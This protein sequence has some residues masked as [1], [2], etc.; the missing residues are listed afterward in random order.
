MSKH[1]PSR[2]NINEIQDSLEN[3]RENWEQVNSSLLAKRELLTQEIIENL[4]AGYSYVD[5]LIEN[6]IDIFDD[7]SKM[8][9][10][11]HIVLCWEDRSQWI[12]SNNHIIETRKS[13]ELWIDEILAWHEKKKRK[14]KSIYKIAAWVYAMW[15]SQPQLFIEWNH[16]T[17]SL[18]ASYL[19][20]SQWRPP[21]VLTK[22]NA[23]AF[24]DPST[25][26]K[27]SH[28]A[29]FVDRRYYIKKYRKALAEFLEDNLDKKFRI[30]DK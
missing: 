23:K 12:N 22:E 17:W 29:K 10:L 15:V 5:F 20:V 30:K 26:L 27:S 24:F 7:T 19:L 8:L 9:D 25:L 14:K 6:Q 28:K 21:F 13:F 4:L 11:N 1:R 18:I 3:V 16:R 2:L